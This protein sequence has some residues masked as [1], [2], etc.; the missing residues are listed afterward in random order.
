MNKI[1]ETLNR[2][3]GK[4]PF[5]NLMEK[6]P[7]ETRNKIPLLNTLIPLSNYIVTGLLLV[8]LISI[9]SG[10][11]GL[12]LEESTQWKDDSRGY[13]IILQNE[14]NLFAGFFSQLSY[15]TW[16][17]SGNKLTVT[18]NDDNS[19]EEFK[20]TR[21]AITNSNGNV[22]KRDTEW[23]KPAPV[24]SNN[25]QTSGGSSQQQ[26]PRQI[27][28]VEDDGVYIGTRFYYVYDNRGSRDRV[29]AEFM[30]TNRPITVSHRGNKLIINGYTSSGNRRY[31]EYTLYSDRGIRSTRSDQETVIK[32]RKKDD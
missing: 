15:G 14:P 16:K 10:G 28:R 20:I 18:Y 9:I 25:T 8:I 11:G 29:S 24:A 19:T 5:K 13:T 17:V 1:F 32:I 23:D 2:L 7:T 27:S 3:L 30:Y 6:I 12:G 22:Y 26:S 21:N 4:L 31:V